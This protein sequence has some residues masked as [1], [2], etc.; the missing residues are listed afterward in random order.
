LKPDHFFVN[1]LDMHTVWTAKDAES[2]SFEGR[3]RKSG[4]L[5]Y[6]ATR[7]DLVFGSNSV[8]RLCRGL[9]QR[10]RQ[11]KAR[12]RLRGRL[13]QGDERGSL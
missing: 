9:R 4:Q 3:D 8:L 1:L 12:Q 10:V 13:G 11:R 7:N 6:T 2:E 5:K